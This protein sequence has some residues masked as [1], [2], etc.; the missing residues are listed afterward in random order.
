MDETPSIRFL[1]R[2]T[3]APNGLV[4]LAQEELIQTIDNV[5]QAY[6]GNNFN[7]MNGNTINDGS[8]NLHNNDNNWSN[9]NTN[10]NRIIF[11]I[12][13][14]RGCTISSL[15]RRRFHIQ[16]FRWTL[17]SLNSGSSSTISCVSW[18][19][20][21]FKLILPFVKFYVT[22]ATRGRIWRRSTLQI[23]EK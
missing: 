4:Q 14:I 13:N 15:S 7:T 10:I 9:H 12:T 23:D 19:I 6:N 2:K 3:I 16:L 20:C 11:P 21:L 18:S 8:R 22:F 1:V 5:S 17:P